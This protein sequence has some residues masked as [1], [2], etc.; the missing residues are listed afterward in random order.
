MKQINIFLVILTAIILT[1]G[2]AISSDMKEKN[3]KARATQEEIYKLTKEFKN[4]KR[5]IQLQREEE[6]R[7]KQYRK[8]VERKKNWQKDSR[9]NNEHFLE[10]A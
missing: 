9:V 1:H 7:R 4:H 8:D 3:K 5:E 6:R 2:T 10:I